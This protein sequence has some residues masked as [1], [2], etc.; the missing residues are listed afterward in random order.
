[1]DRHFL[2]APF[3]RNLPVLLGLI[4]VWNSQYLG[5]PARALAC[6]SEALCDFAAHVQQVD[7]ESNGK[8]VTADGRLVY[9]TD[10]TGAVVRDETGAPVPLSYGEV[11]FG[12]SG[13]N[14]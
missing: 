12:Q 11:D 14:S 4:G 9:A 10:A 8:R 1:M 13:T 6:Y 3:E 2:T 7:M 5:Y